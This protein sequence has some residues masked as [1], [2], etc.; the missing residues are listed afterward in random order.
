M[1]SSSSHLATVCIVS[2]GCAKN[3]VDTEVMCGHLAVNGF[4]LTDTE[5]NAD[6]VLI[7]TCSFIQD[8]RTESA[9]AIEQA[10]VWRREDPNRR[11]A[12]SGCWPQQDGLKLHNNYPE[13]D[14]LLGLDSVPRIAAELKTILAETE[15][16]QSL[17]DTVNSRSTYLYDHNE[18][19]LQLT[20]PS[21]AY[22]KI[23]EGCNHSCSFCTIPSIRGRLR[24]RSVDSIVEEGKMLLQNGV[25][26][27]NF[28]AQDTTSYGFDRRQPE[29]LCD[30][31]E[32]FEEMSND[33]WLRLLYTHPAHVGNNF[34]ARLN[35]S[36]HLVP[37]LDMPLQHIDDS[38]LRAMG[39]SETGEKE[40]R[41][42][43][44]RIRG[45]Y[46]D[47]TIRTT[48]IVGYPGETEKEFNKLE[49]LLE[50]YEFEHV[51]IFQYSPEPGTRAAAL[52]APAPSAETSEERRAILMKLQ[53]EISLKN[54]QD[55]IGRTIPVLVESQEGTGKWRGRSKGDAPDVDNLVYF[56]GDDE[57]YEPGISNV[58]ITQADIYDLYGEAVATFKGM[59]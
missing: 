51:G 7:N 37:Y 22:I 9:E 15:E 59:N 38:I 30:L 33:F 45:D 42:L 34:L 19:R 44:D 4:L 41:G 29:A 23:A 14:L 12:V 20:P 24:S 25:R 58:T 57:M 5:E 35:N 32:K 26:E 55:I 18:P 49:A 50:E 13:I 3:L 16:K 48:F 53:Q 1:N 31:L 52:S 43:L 2:L 11:L 8:A 56:T 40:I 28:I 6:I 36:N 39:R 47:I 10:L 54:N 21:Y 27:L 17:S 46:P